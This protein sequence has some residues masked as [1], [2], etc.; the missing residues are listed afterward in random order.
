V[1]WYNGN[2]LQLSYS[3][4]DLF[5]DILVSKLFYWVKTCGLSKRKKLEKSC[6]QTSTHKV[7]LVWHSEYSM[8]HSSTGSAQDG[9]LL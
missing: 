4:E 6:K 3:L 7:Q 2:I 9:Q 5:W 1:I 8:Q